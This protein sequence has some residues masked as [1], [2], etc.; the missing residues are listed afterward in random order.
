ME[1]VNDFLELEYVLDKIP[2]S[3]Y[4]GTVL[5]GGQSV[6]LWCLIL[7]I[8]TQNDYLTSDV[9][10]IGSQELAIA[11]SKEIK[12]K[13]TVKVASL[14]DSSINTAIISIFPD[15][16]KNSISIDYLMRVHGLDASDIVKTAIDIALD[17]MVIK[18]IHPLLLMQSKLSNLMLPTKQNAEAITQ[19]KL[20]IEVLRQFI[21]QR[22]SL[23]DVKPHDNLKLINKIVRVSRT[24]FLVNAYKK[25]NINSMEAIPVDEM[26]RSGVSEYVKFVEIGL[27]NALSKIDKFRRL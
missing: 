5:V 11:A 14:G 19:A 10:L 15:D 16:R 20:S 1:Q 6:N 12:I 4:P 8:D 22:M 3:I 24:A 17:E 9:D 2:E 26:K 23:E 13:N 25:F 27:P 21:L 18:I 7:G